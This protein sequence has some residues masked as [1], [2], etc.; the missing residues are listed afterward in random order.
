RRNAKA[1]LRRLTPLSARALACS[2]A[3]EKDP[4]GALCH[5]PPAKRP[6]SAPS[7]PNV[8]PVRKTKIRNV[9]Y[10]AQERISSE[11]KPYQQRP[12]SDETRRSRAVSVTW[13]EGTEL[14]RKTSKSAGKGPKDQQQACVESTDDFAQPTSNDSSKSQ[15]DTPRKD[16]RSFTQVL[17]DTLALKMLGRSPSIQPASDISAQGLQSSTQADEPTLS[18]SDG[19]LQNTTEE[20]SQGI[21]PLT[22]R[23]RKDQH[24]QN[25]QRPQLESRRPSNSRKRW[26][27][28]QPVSTG[29]AYNSE[30]LTPSENSAN[31]YEQTGS[32]TLKQGNLEYYK[33]NQLRS[34]ARTSVRGDEDAL[35][36]EN[37]S[38]DFPYTNGHVVGSLQKSR[39]ILGANRSAVNVQNKAFETDT[40]LPEP[41]PQPNHTKVKF[42]AQTLSQL[43]RESLEGL[44][45]L[46]NK[47]AFESRSNEKGESHD[48]P[49]ERKANEAELAK[50]IDQSVFYVLK[51]PSRIRQSF[52]IKS[53]SFT[54]G[55]DSDKS[56]SLSTQQ[57]NE[58]LELL[59]CM[60][61]MH[62]LCSQDRIWDS[63]WISL[64]YLF[65]PPPGLARSLKHRRGIGR[66][67]SYDDS[68]RRYQSISNYPGTRKKFI[69]D[70]EA[71]RICIIALLAL[72]SKALELSHVPEFSIAWSSLQS[73]GEFGWR[74]LPNETTATEL[75]K[76]MYYKLMDT[77]DS[78]NG[79]RLIGRLVTAISNRVA[80]NA[81]EKSKPKDPLMAGLRGA[82]RN[83]SI[84]RKIWTDIGR[85]PTNGFASKQIVASAI[86]AW[87]KIL[88]TDEWD[89][90]VQIRR[91]SVLGGSLQL[92]A[93]VYEARVDLNLEV[94]HFYI[95]LFSERLDPMEVPAEWLAFH[96][97]NKIFHLLSFPFLFI[98]SALVQYFR[99]INHASMWK[100]FESATTQS[101]LAKQLLRE[102]TVPIHNELDLLLRLR[103]SMATF[104]VLNV[105]RDH[106][107]TD[108]IDLLW[109]REK[110][111]LLRPLKVK[112]GMELGE[113]GVDAG[114]VQ[115]EFFRILFA[116]ALNPDFGMFTV[117]ER[118]RM[119]WYQPASQEPLY[120]FEMLGLLMSL[121]VYNSVT[122]SVT[123]PLAFY[124]K[125]LGLKVK[126]L[127]HIEDGWPDLA[128]GLRDLL[129]WS[130]GD[131]AD[132]F[133]RTY[134]FSYEAF[135]THVDVDME[136]V[137]RE[138]PWPRRKRSKGKEKS[139][140]AS[141]DFSSETRSALKEESS[142]SAG[143]R[144]PSSFAPILSTPEIEDEPSGS[145][146][147]SVHVLL[148]TISVPATPLNDDPKIHTTMTATMA[149]RDLDPDLDNRDSSASLVTNANRAQYI[150]D[151]IFW[152]TDKSIRAQHEA[153]LR[154][155]LVC[156]SPRAISIFTPEA[157]KSLVE[158]S[159]HIDID[160]LERI[161][162]YV[163][164]Y[165]STHRVIQWFWQVVKEEFDDEDRRRLLEFVTAS[166]RL[167]VTGVDALVFVVQRAG[168]EDGRLPT[169]HTCFGR[170]LLPEY[171][172]K[173]V[174]AR[175]LRRAVWDTRGFYMA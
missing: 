163:D 43:D 134:E 114:G 162:R 3:S 16:L 110:R 6:E 42:E 152:L 159:S 67:S 111:E 7:V 101:H 104:L 29:E 157:L 156:L 54:S 12:K 113:E 18:S 168:D 170:L 25:E 75:E 87:A 100:A 124:R 123:F 171:S 138:A 102:D 23:R 151:Y 147:R 44:G 83:S 68:C 88:I 59:D 48:T 165:S 10:P 146:N 60:C 143:T 89:G 81:M 107:L 129:E 106:V 37:S 62:R 108:A 139:K 11:A 174:L 19:N 125:L 95:Q 74:S 17:F 133:M 26:D 141:F 55:N 99:A 161:A 160:G 116:E 80:F 71:A 144:R 69:H 172:K 2:L 105:R 39:P 50:F 53:P 131:V 128:K 85:L 70:V 148:G 65:T 173:E 103:P 20:V 127:E 36:D 21:A 169:S 46:V 63:L 49:E 66:S 82:F 9:P 109:R 13:K 14:V 61:L 38:R 135:G 98:P 120:K 32:Q 158:G 121:A 27:D 94:S 164:G 93:S 33:Q 4:E 96:P 45:S 8:S 79:K 132:V 24:T 34:Y 84:L 142:H 73:T 136:K 40:R 76:D 167:P 122:L 153:L 51:D 30:T 149:S 175:Q 77:L 126:K 118:T 52:H 22:D 72:A 92:L 15:Y 86:L 117:D 97:D 47:N 155:F 166:D 78:S 90:K 154:G 31:E 137:G 35:A 112:M 58:I 119:A 145:R 64:G 140:S 41:S 115:Q 28:L 56:G 91:S 5:N 1:P 57:S 150:K 130:N